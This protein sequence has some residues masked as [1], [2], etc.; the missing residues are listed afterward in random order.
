MK[1][2]SGLDIDLGNK[3]SQN[4][5]DWAKRTFINRKDKAGEIQID[6]D[7]TF[8]N[9]LKFDNARIG[10][11]SDG[12]GTKIELA[13]RTGIYNTIGFDL[14]AM[15]A[16]DLI[17]NGFEPTN[18]S[19]IIDID[20]LDYDVIDQMMEGLFE[21]AKQAN[22]TI[23]GGEIAELGERMNG[24]GK[25]PHFN[26]CATAIG[27]LPPILKRPVSGADAKAGDKII[28]LK[29]R[30]FRSNGFSLV[31]KVME[32]NFGENWHQE[33]YDSTTT[34]GKKLLTP[35]LIF[36]NPVSQLISQ[37][38]ELHG[39]AHITGGGLVDNLNR[40]LKLNKLGAELDDIYAPPAFVKKVQEIGKI[41]EE[42][43][44]RL[45]NMGNGMLLICPEKSADKIVENMA[46]LRYDAKI[47]GQVTAERQI[48]IQSKGINA[49]EL[50]Y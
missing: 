6:V 47:C 31:R 21:A 32:D 41:S 28:S 23:S 46:E 11:S 20:H 24:F 12:I 10:I 40:V 19:N 35:S 22:V 14:M 3:C 25:G 36:C 38:I 45:W 37:G 16:D 18:I 13:E 42:Q 43:A 15:V 29:S 4:A 26:W 5:Y 8:S 1:K 39:I 2:D 49:Q 7:G 33:K 48:C 30:G 44:Y 50:C 9:M 27:Y 34:W 17:A